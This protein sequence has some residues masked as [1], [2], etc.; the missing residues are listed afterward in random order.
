MINKI[1]KAKKES[2]LANVKEQIQLELSE[3][4][5]EN[6]DELM[7]KS[8]LENILKKYGNIKYDVNQNIESLVVED[9]YEIK[10]SEIYNDNLI[11]DIYYVSNEEELKNVL[12][13]IKKYKYDIV[14]IVVIDNF[15]LNTPIELKDIELSI[16][17]DLTLNVNACITAVGTSTIV[18]NQNS[19][20]KRASTYKGNLINEQKA[21]KVT[22]KNII[23]DG[24]TV[25]TG[26]EDEFLTRGMIPSVVANDATLNFGYD[27]Q[28][29]NIVIEKCTFK[30]CV[31]SE[32]G[33]NIYIGRPGT[34]NISNSSFEDNSSGSNEK[35]GSA[36]VIWITQYP[37]VNIN[38]CNFFRNSSIGT[39]YYNGGGAIRIQN[40]YVTIRNSNFKNNAAYNGNYGG[41]IHLAN[42]GLAI[43]DSNFDK[44][45]ANSG[46]SIRATGSVFAYNT[47][48]SNNKGM[49]G[50]VISMPNNTARFSNCEFNKNE[51]N[52]NES[53]EL[54]YCIWGNNMYFES[55]K[56]ENNKNN[57]NS[58]Y[59]IVAANMY[60]SGN[61]IIQNNT[62]LKNNISTNTDIRVDNNMQNIYITGKLN[63][64]SKINIEVDENIDNKIVA[65][66]KNYTITD[67]DLKA[68]YCQDN[69]YNLKINEDNN[70]IIIEKIIK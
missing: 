33:G 50:G 2:N 13:I 42:G 39:K 6:N 61:M 35:D 52:S 4:K 36:G 5:I 12:D 8:D 56:L 53:K 64:E 7:L 57:S 26:S 55:C 65:Y 18:G 28:R 63:E 31:T 46:S 49:A 40:G 45:Y 9:G 17:S 11:S 47:I 48:F 10:I 43:Y 19:T 23:M 16:N 60:V 29:C 68:F 1:V 44:N 70:T 59:N 34:V 38:N 66:G 54:G 37:T 15:T 69:K 32:T 27:S 24:S 41:A 14:K 51:G 58:I 22:L 62:S 25:W 30:N 21:S 20:I 3:N 67:S